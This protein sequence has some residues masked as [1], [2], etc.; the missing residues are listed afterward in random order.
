MTRH[1]AL[2][3]ISPNVKLP[4]NKKK[5]GRRRVT[6]SPSLSPICRSVSLLNPLTEEFLKLAEVIKHPDDF[7]QDIRGILSDLM[8]RDTSGPD[9]LFTIIS[10]CGSRS[11]TIKVETWMVILM[12]KPVAGASKVRGGNWRH[13]VH[14]ANKSNIKG[15]HWT[16]DNRYTG[17][18]SKIIAMKGEFIVKFIC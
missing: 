2:S 11:F 9:K 12:P 15:F 16:K 17:K 3:S 13:M 18:P 14:G 1:N 8:A 5:K 7:V 6:D 4:F 10:E